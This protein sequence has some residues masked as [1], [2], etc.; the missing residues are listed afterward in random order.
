MTQKSLQLAAGSDGT[1]AAANAIGQ[2]ISTVPTAGAIITYAGNGVT[3]RAVAGT[4]T[5]T[6]GVWVVNAML[7]AYPGSA[8]ATTAFAGWL[9]LYNSTDAA[10][11]TETPRQRYCAN[12][13]GAILSDWSESFELYTH[14]LLTGTKTIQVRICGT[15][16]Y[17]LSTGANFTVRT[18]G[19]NVYESIYAIRIA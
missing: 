10:I 14:I 13:P 18:G 4:L 16:D 5:L 15:N 9:D 2:K 6:A 19:A 8:P 3:S 7:A 1:A 17:G 12:F 11:L